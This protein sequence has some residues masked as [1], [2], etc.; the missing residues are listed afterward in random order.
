MK[1]ID[2]VPIQTTGAAWAAEAATATVTATVTGMT[3]TMTEWPV[4]LSGTAAGIATMEADMG[5]TGSRTAAALAA[6]VEGTAAVMAAEAGTADMVRLRQ[7]AITTT[8]AVTEMVARRVDTRI[9]GMAEEGADMDTAAGTM[10]VGRRPAGTMAT[11]RPR[12]VALPPTTGVVTD[13]VRRLPVSSKQAVR[14]AIR[15]P[16]RQSSS[17]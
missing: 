8:G 14:G 15:G 7:E 4:R 17:S 5:A 12:A 11:T 6:A 2:T 9:A 1:E 13:R 3:A 10:V 16:A